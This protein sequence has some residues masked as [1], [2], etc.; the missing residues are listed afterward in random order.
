[1]GFITNR[2]TITR[3]GGSSGRVHV[4]Y[5]VTNGWYTDFHTTNRF[6]TN[7]YFTNTVVDLISHLTNYFITNITVTNI[8]IVNDY[9][10]MEYGELV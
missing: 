10:N 9:Q 1:M 8:L 3:T 7:L 5:T 4:D 6:G 2:F